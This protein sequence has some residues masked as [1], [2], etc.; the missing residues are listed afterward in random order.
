MKFSTEVKIEAASF[1]LA[2]QSKVVLLG[3]CFADEVGLRL[4]DCLPDGHVVVNPCGVLYN[5]ESI[6]QCINL[7]LMDESSQ[8]ATLEESLFLSQDG[9]WH[10]WLFS[11]KFSALTHDECLDLCLNAIKGILLDADLLSITLGT[12]HCYRLRVDN[13]IVAN[14]HKEPASRFSEEIL[15]E[16]GS[17]CDSLVA[18]HAQ[19]PTLRVVMTV[20]PYRY[21]KYGMHASQLSKARLLLLVDSLSHKLPFVSYFPA[22]E[23]VLDELRDYRFYAPDMLHPSSQAA[24]YVFERFV[25]WCFSQQLLTFAAERQKALRRERHRPII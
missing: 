11:T 24:D 3:S 9:R 14:C 15:L 7:L 13:R 1:R 20:S 4:S 17:L 6:A 21:A 10:S 23:I 16:S 5:P 19:Y 22:Y 8:R 12:D 2:P 25:E 18:L